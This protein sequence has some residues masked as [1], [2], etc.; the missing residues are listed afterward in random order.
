MCH[1]NITVWHFVK[2][3][4]LIKQIFSFQDKGKLAE[5][6]ISQMLRLLL[7]YKNDVFEEAFTSGVLVVF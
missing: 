6:F 7:T 4:F 3:T 2:E 1:E 5:L